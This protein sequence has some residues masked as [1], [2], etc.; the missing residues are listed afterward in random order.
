MI[1]GKFDQRWYS[2]KEQEQRVSSQIERY[3]PDEEDQ[4]EESWKHDSFWEQEGESL[5]NLPSIPSFKMSDFITRIL[6]IPNKKGAYAPFSFEGRAHLPAIYDTPARFIL[7]CCA[8]QVEK[9]V[10]LRT[11]ILTTNGLL[12]ASEISEGDVVLSYDTRTSKLVWKPVLWKSPTVRKPALRITLQGGAQVVCG[13]DHPFRGYRQWILAKDLVKGSRV[14][15]A[16]ETPE[17]PGSMEVPVEDVVRAG[18]F[19]ALRLMGVAAHAE[20]RPFL[21]CTVRHRHQIVPLLED[22]LYQVAEPFEGKYRVPKG[23]WTV[24]LRGKLGAV[25][26]ERKG[27]GFSSNLSCKA[28][29]RSARVAV[30]AMWLIAGVLSERANRSGSLEMHIDVGNEEEAEEVR[31]IHLMAG[32]ELSTVKHQHG[33]GGA[34]GVWWRMRPIGRGKRKLLS[35][36]PRELVSDFPEADPYW[37]DDTLPPQWASSMQRVYSERVPERRDLEHGWYGKKRPG[38]RGRQGRK[39]SRS[40]SLS[41]S[42]V[43]GEEAIETLLQ[44][45]GAHPEELYLLKRELE[46]P[47]RWSRVMSVEPLGEME[48]VDFEVEGTHTFVA[49]GAITHNSTYLGNR[50]L[51]SSVAYPGYKSLYVSPSSIQTKTFSSDRLRNPIETSPFLQDFARAGGVQN[52]LEMEFGNSSKITMRSAYLSADR[53]R[54]IPA[55]LLCMDEFQDLLP[56]HIPV[57]EPCTSHAPRDYRVHLYAGTPKSFDNNMEFYRSGFSADRPMSTMGEWMV[58]C[59]HC[60]VKGPGGW[61]FWQSLGVKNIQKKG[62]SCS[63]CGGSLDPQHADAR[64][65]HQQADGRFESYRIPQLMVPWRPWDELY[66]DYINFDN[67]KFHNEVLGL[68][69][70]NHQRPLSM[71]EMRDCC[72]PRLPM[73][74]KDAFLPEK[75]GDHIFMGVDWGSGTL[76]YTVMTLATYVGGIFTI[77]YMQRFTGRLLDVQEQIDHVLHTLRRFKV[78][79][80]GTDFGY[81]AQNNDHLI[82]WYGRDRIAV[83]QHLGRVTKKIAFDPRMQRFKVFRSAVMAD[84][85]NMIKRKNIRFPRWEDMREPFAKDFCNITSELSETQQMMIYSHRPDRPDDSFHSALYCLMASTLVVQRPDIFSPLHN[86]YRQGPVRELGGPVDQG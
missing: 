30:K 27:K 67:A 29:V 36:L 49:N 77:F 7:L 25:L 42:R 16:N 74:L 45:E 47:T 66:T 38:Q 1:T 64:W 21:S 52:V 76:S 78:V 86:S 54:G 12:R 19:D 41:L 22:V 57:I 71:S 65:V 26:A 37:E 28:G 39:G 40:P 61:R 50:L 15:V 17:I 48:M 10:S 46:A 20:P 82:R 24:W 55:Y 5:G 6:R 18:V 83:Y 69:M 70:D 63:Q 53:C 44:V 23:R 11:P 35:L 56:E 73:A 72:D 8:R 59:D 34:G 51:V 79:V 32:I 4:L 58:P 43:R 9:C 85:I 81:G 3:D 62:L 14:E 2:G 13:E 68:S 84:F 75:W 80:C 33:P 60:G 31:A